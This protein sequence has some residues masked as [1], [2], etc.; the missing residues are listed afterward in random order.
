MKKNTAF[1]IALGTAFA[2]GQAVWAAPIGAQVIVQ[3]W[4]PRKPDVQTI[5]TP[6]DSRSAISDAVIGAW[7]KVRNDICSSLMQQMGKRNLLAKG[8]TLYNINCTLSDGELLSSQNGSRGLKLAYRVKNVFIEATSTTPDIVRGIHIDKA[9]DPRFSVA[10]NLD[11]DLKLALRETGDVLSVSPTKVWVSNA[12]IDSKNV[13]GNI[14]QWYDTNLMPLIKGQSFRGQVES[15]LNSINVNFANK[16]NT[17]L[18]PLNNAFRLPQNLIRSGLWARPGEVYTA[19]APAEWV[20]PTDGQWRGRKSWKN[21]YVKLSGDS[22]AGFFMSA[23]VKTG[24]APIIDPVTRDT[25]PAPRR[26]VG[27][28]VSVSPATEVGDSRECG[29]TL[30]EL[31]TG[32]PV[33]I[34]GRLSV[35]QKP[36]KAT[37]SAWCRCSIADQTEEASGTFDGAAVSGGEGD[38]SGHNYKAATKLIWRALRNI[39]KNGQYQYSTWKPRWCNSPSSSANHLKTC[40]IKSAD[41]GIPTNRLTHKTHYIPI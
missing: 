33:V 1:A 25:G 37:L 39:T 22:C 16:V 14:L 20:P 21:T 38:H 10:F 23:S 13:S 18:A 7:S 19:F 36:N 40:G 29:Y 8:I 3:T 6:Y 24:P 15:A 4:D 31:P 35:G 34:S 9:V 41:N 27:Q 17:A 28:M 11:L 30:S 32:V 5:H 26:T 2:W 12:R